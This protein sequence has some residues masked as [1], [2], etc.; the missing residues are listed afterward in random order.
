MFRII[1]NLFYNRGDPVIFAGEVISGEVKKNDYVDV[2]LPDKILSIGRI[3]DLQIN[4]TSQN[5][6]TKGNKAVFKISATNATEA[7]LRMN[8]DYP[9][10]ATFKTRE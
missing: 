9:M 8:I 3:S 6:V 10:D 2:V 5:S 7:N 1:P 4:N